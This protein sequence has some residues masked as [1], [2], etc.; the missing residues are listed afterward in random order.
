MVDKLKMNDNAVF[1]CKFVCCI[2]KIF[3]SSVTKA[4]Q[5]FNKNIT[6]RLL[7]FTLTFR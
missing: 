2:D 6:F 3:L 1:M 4:F 5:K 7:K